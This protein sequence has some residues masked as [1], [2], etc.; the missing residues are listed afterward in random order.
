MQN[1]KQFIPLKVSMGGESDTPSLKA[2][3]FA[4]T[5]NAQRGSTNVD[6]TAAL[7]ASS[8][9]YSS[10]QVVQNAAHVRTSQGSPKRASNCSA[11]SVS[12]SAA[13]LRPSAVSRTSDTAAGNS[14]A[15]VYGLDRLDAKSGPFRPSL[16]QFA[17]NSNASCLDADLDDHAIARAVA[18]TRSLPRELRD[19]ARNLS[20][21]SADCLLP[22]QVRCCST[23][24][25]FSVL[26]SDHYF[27]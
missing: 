8:S 22:A 6:N 10:M 23:G 15:A 14:R 17:R 1:I 27:A 7:A 24:Q 20:A 26:T 3:S 5:H 9:F 19:C 4:T 11:T 13:R 21:F 12:S 16:N 2:T 18:V 25:L